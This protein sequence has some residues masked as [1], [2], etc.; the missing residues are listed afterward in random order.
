[1]NLNPCDD[2]FVFVRWQLASAEHDAR[3]RVGCDPC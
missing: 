3:K 2:E 1:M